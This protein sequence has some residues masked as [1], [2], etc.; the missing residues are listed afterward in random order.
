MTDANKIN[1]AI[2]AHARWKHVLKEAIETKKSDRSLADVKS[3]NHCEFG[4]WLLELPLSDRQ[5]KHWQTVRP[6]HAEFHQV[7][8][9][10]LELALAGKREQAEAEMK[11]SGNFTRLSTKLTIAMTNWKRDVSGG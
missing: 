1:Q 11:I 4:Q 2:A 6:L 9:K 10:V 8:A 3:E 5:S 7:A